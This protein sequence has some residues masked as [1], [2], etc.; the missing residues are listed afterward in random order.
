M[1]YFDRIALTANVVDLLRII[2]QPLHVVPDFVGDDIGTSKFTRRVQLALHIRVKIEIDIHFRIARTVKRPDRGIG[3]AAGRL[4]LSAK[5]NENWLLILP[6]LL[7]KQIGPD[8][9]G[10]M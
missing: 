9:F 2:E 4:H 1:I 8:D 7:T 10:V 3:R 6:I 5:E